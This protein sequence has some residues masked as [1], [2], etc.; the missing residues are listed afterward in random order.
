MGLVLRQQGKLDEALKHYK[1]AV[2]IDPNY[3]DAHI[4]M[5]VTLDKKGDLQEALQC[6]AKAIQINPEHAAAHRNMGLVSASTR[7]AG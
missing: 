1:E 5:G 4:N 7:Q 3:A 6:Y 2:R